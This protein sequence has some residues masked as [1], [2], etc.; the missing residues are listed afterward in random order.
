MPALLLSLLPLLLKYAPDLVGLAMGGSAQAVAA[1]VAKAATEVFGTDDGAAIAQQVAADP[2]KADA[3]ATRLQA[4]TDQLKATLADVQSAR[5]TT[6]A[7]AQAGSSIAWG[8]PVVSVAVTFGFIAILLVMTLHA[9]PDSGVVNVLVGTLATA[10]GQVVNYWL[11][12]SAGSQAKT[13]QLSAL[14]HA[15]L[16]RA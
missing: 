14:A 11:G 15:G 6:V 7:L 1:K 12:S 2:A 4:E 3:F 9:L 5:G 13:Q 10:F 8:A 16:H